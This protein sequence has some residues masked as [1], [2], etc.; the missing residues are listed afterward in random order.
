LCSWCYC[1][2]AAAA[3]TTTGADNLVRSSAGDDLFT[4]CEELIAKAYYRRGA[5]IAYHEC[6]EPAVYP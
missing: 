4:P 3:T 6:G 2:A 1:S 5:K